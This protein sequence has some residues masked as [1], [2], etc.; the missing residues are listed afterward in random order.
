[1][2]T[3]LDNN[4]PSMHNYIIANIDATFNNASVTNVDVFAYI[5]FASSLCTLASL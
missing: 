3:Y 4:R 5:D 1:V 2:Y